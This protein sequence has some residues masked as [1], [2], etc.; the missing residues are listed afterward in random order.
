MDDMNV[1]RKIIIILLG[2]LMILAALSIGVYMNPTSM[3]PKNV[4]VVEAPG[5][6][7]AMEHP[8][9]M[10][11][12]YETILPEGENIAIGGKV[13]VSGFT[14][15]YTGRKAIDGNEK[16]A[17]YWE[18]QADSYPNWIMVELEQ[19]L[20]VNGIR[21]CLNPSSI[22]GKRVQ[23]FQVEIS[24]DNKIFTSLYD[25]QDCVFDPNRG[26]EVIW[27]FDSVLASAVR[28]TFTQNTGA[29]G[30]QVAELEIYSK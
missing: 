29:T 28:L 12:G 4:R 3:N 6:T 13:T 24:E 18:A 5:Q 23:T 22:W 21:I 2:I 27:I 17:S 10:A 11:E 20:P 16:G 8:D 19:T 7:S 26:N 25:M 15:I 9:F 1:R 30:A 14:D